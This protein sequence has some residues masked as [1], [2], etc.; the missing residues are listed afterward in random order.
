MTN[1]NAKA[2]INIGI[3]VKDKKCVYTVENS[4]TV[5]Q[6]EKGDKPGIGLQNVKRRL[7]LSYPGEYELDISETEEKYMVKLNLSLH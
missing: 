7:E 6:N 4:K 2:W 5:K 1:T 3:Q